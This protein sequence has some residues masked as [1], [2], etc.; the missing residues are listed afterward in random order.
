M[1]IEQIEK[2]DGIP[3][4]TLVED[5]NTRPD[6]VLRVLVGLVNDS[7]DNGFEWGWA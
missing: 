1:T 3:T 7:K 4:R 2:P 5:I 6:D